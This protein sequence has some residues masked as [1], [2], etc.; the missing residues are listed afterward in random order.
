METTLALLAVCLFPALTIL[1]AFS[2]LFNMTIPNWLT[3][4]L[5][6]AFFAAAPLAGLGVSE[7]ALHTA[8]GAAMLAVGFAMF[9]RG[10]IGGGDAKLFAAAALWL[11]WENVLQYGLGATLL[12]GA[13]SV[14]VLLLR[15][16]PLLPAGCPAWLARLHDRREGVP[17][18][19]ALAV[20]AVFLYSNSVY[21]ARLA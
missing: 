17:Y 16:A 6:L 7:I 15:T 20:A 21:I 14:L 1:A 9:A 10:W 4:A 8:C 12:G 3:A 18:G 13:L 5:A 2:D 19:I 11:G